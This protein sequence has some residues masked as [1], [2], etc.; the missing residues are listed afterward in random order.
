M[1]RS[2]LVALVPDQVGRQIIAFWVL[3]MLSMPRKDFVLVY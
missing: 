2:R 3:P 1:K